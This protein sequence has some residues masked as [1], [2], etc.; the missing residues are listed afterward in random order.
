MPYEKNNATKSKEEIDAYIDSITRGTYSA[1]ANGDMVLKSAGASYVP[2]SNYSGSSNVATDSGVHYA[3]GSTYVDGAGSG[4]NYN[5]QVAAAMTN[6]STRAPVYINGSVEYSNGTQ[7]Y[8]SKAFENVDKL[9]MSNIQGMARGMALYYDKSG[10]SNQ[11][12]GT[13]DAANDNSTAYNSKKTIPDFHINITTDGAKGVD[14]EKM[15]QQIQASVTQIVQ[16][17]MGNTA[18]VAATNYQRAQTQY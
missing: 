6:S 1:D 13:I 17:N 11:Y 8:N 16:Q 14:Y 7:H 18:K 12:T 5:S 15:S 4:A 2:P 10:Q 9:A 3:S